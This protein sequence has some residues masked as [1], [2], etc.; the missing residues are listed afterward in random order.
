MQRRKQRGMRGYSLTE[1]L[2]VVGMVGV[3]TM[4]SLPAFMTV[5]PQYRIRGAASELTATLRM[6]RSKAIS[7]R[8]QWRVTVDPAGE[9]YWIEQEQ[10]P[11][12]G[13]WV[14]INH[15]GRPLTTGQQWEKSL[16]A[17]LQPDGANIIVTFNRQGV[18]NASSVVV[19]VDNSFVRFNRYTINIEASGNVTVVPSKV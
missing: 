2:A 12:S 9:N 6:V 8:T 16:G 15:L 17:D 14:A 13:T 5:I 18:A 1:M 3:I 7:T 10:V 11:N 4:V 19:A